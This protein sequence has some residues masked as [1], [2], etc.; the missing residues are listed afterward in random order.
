M[1]LLRR[2]SQVIFTVTNFH[3]SPL[4]QDQFMKKRENESLKDDGVNLKNDGK[5]T[6]QLTY[7]KFIF[8]LTSLK[9]SVRI[10]IFLKF[11]KLSPGLKKN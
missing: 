3:Q 4:N 10:F 2:D 9:V 11:Y 7:A 8:H 5:Q 1:A 6:V